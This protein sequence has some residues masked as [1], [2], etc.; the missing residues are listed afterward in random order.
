MFEIILI[1]FR[2]H[3]DMFIDVYRLPDQHHLVATAV[4][5]GL[6]TRS[7]IFNILPPICRG[8]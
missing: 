8:R 5:V 6:T 7:G 3:L 1:S 4:A 2:P